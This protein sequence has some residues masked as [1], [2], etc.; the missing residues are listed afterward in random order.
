MLTVIAEKKNI[1][2]TKIIIDNKLDCGHIQNVYRLQINDEVR[3]IDG[4][5]EYLTKILSISKKEVVLEIIKKMEDNYSLDVNID[6]AI[7]ILK[8]DKM[9]LVIQKLTEIGVNKIIPLKTKRVVVKINE[10]KEKW[11]TVVREA[12]KQCRGV[13][14]PKVSEIKKIC[15]IDYERYDKII[16]AYE[17]SENSKPIFELINKKDKN[18]LC[19][20]GPEGGITKEEVNF[21]KEK[22]AFE[23]SLG[24][25][26]LRAET[27]SIVVAGIISNLKLK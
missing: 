26:I 22:N 8:N 21:L 23:V 10:K 14:F 6:M 27:A 12:L 17:N 11:E 16:F 7:G 25:R 5:F 13:K 4:E 19:V 2:D 1:S 20:I 15:E 18:I 24:A 9:N 3:V